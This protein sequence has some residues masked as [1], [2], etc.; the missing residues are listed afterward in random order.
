MKTSYVMVSRAFAMFSTGFSSPKITTL[1]PM[2][3]FMPFRF[4]IHMSMQMF[5]I[6]G[7]MFPLTHTL[8]P[9]GERW[10][11]SPSA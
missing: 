5:P 11:L 2:E 8:K 7:A 1:S 3:A 10:R 4:I 9:F 6:I